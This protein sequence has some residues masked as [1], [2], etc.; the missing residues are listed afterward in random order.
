[1]YEMKCALGTHRISTYECTAA[2]TN[3]IVA[4]HVRTSAQADMYKKE[5][6]SQNLS[7]YSRVYA[8][9]YECFSSLSERL[10]YTQ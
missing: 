10:T 3:I 7:P 6:R 1:M 8:Q 5:L 4:P 9:Y 2:H